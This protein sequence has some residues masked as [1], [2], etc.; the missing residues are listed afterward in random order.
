M[1]L[2]LVPL[3]QEGVDEERNEDGNVVLIYPK[4][5]SRFELILHRYLGGPVVIRRPLDEMGTAIW[6]MCDGK[7]T[8]GEIC[9]NMERIFM[10]KIEPT[11]PRVLKFID[12]LYKLNLIVLLKDKVKSRKMRVIKKE[13]RG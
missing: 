6:D 13:G 9:E 3:K 8:I 7:H 2:N 11:V 4:N 5:L 12:M 10:E 1:I